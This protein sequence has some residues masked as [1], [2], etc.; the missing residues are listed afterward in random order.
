MGTAYF[1]DGHTEKIIYYIK[2]S[3]DYIEFWTES[4]IYV[5]QSWIDEVLDGFRYRAHD[6]YKCDEVLNISTRADI[7][8]IELTKKSMLH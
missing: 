2:S 6:F 1:T 3:E 8:K 4:G 7:E 5:Y